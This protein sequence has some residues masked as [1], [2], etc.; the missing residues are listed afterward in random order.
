MRWFQYKPGIVGETQ[1]VTHC[2]GAADWGQVR[3]WCR[4]C[5]DE[6]LIEAVA[7]PGV[8]PEAGQ[9]SPGMPCIPCLFLVTAATDTAQ[10]AAISGRQVVSGEL[11]PGTS[12]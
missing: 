1:R 9:V 11:P 7:E 5:F 8:E 12:S 2:E 4:R 6:E 3:S 10:D